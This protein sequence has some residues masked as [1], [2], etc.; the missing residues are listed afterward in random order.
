MFGSLALDHSRTSKWMSKAHLGMRDVPRNL[1]QSISLH[2]PAPLDLWWSP[3]EQPVA[4]T[5]T[6]FLLTIFAGGGGDDFDPKRIV[7][8]TPF[9]C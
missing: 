5:R 6:H 8:K 4:Q 9:L 7:V 2:T 1:L 3:E